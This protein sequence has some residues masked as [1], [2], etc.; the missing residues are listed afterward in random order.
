M[1][2]R[3]SSAHCVPDSRTSQPGAAQVVPEAQVER[4]TH[5]GDRQ[6]ESGQR[7]LTTQDSTDGHARNCAGCLPLKGAAS[8]LA[9]ALQLCAAQADVRDP[10]QRMV[11]AVHPAIQSAVHMVAGRVA[12]GG[13]LK[14]LSYCLV[15]PMLEGV[16]GLPN[17]SA[18]HDECLEV[19]SAHVDAGLRDMLPAHMRLVFH[20]VTV[21]SVFNA[22][23][24][25]THP[26]GCS[27]ECSVSMWMS[28]T[29]P[30]CSGQCTALSPKRH[31]LI[32]M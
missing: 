20:L 32:T 11:L 30:M 28:W 3:V 18:L 14:M 21:A 10:S 31:P 24:R 17:R 9:A 22:R 25:T 1:T 2:R 19:L 26:P 8:R 12:S 23:V 7:A 4:W 27:L 16:L 15:F 6:T 13:A 29:R 5:Q